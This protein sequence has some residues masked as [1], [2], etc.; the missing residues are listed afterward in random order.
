[1]NGTT[2]TDIERIARQQIHDRTTHAARHRSRR[3]I[4]RVGARRRGFDAGT[5]A[6]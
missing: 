6:R 2:F 4:R 3:R 5:V 1:M